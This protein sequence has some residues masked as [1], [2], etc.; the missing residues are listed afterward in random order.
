M[1]HR[2]LFRQ[3]R[4]TC[5]LTSDEALAPLM[6][7][8]AELA[9]RDDIAQPVTDF[10]RGLPDLINKVD[11]TYEQSDRDLDLR[12][13]SLEQSSAELNAI[14]EQMRGEI[15]SRNRVL[16]SVRSTIELMITDSGL[17][18]PAEED[19]EGLSAMLPELVKL[20]QARR[21]DLI[22]QRFAMDQ[23]AIVSIT[24]T[25][26]RI[27]YVNDKFCQISG[28]S[29]DELLGQGHKVIN[30]GQH[31]E[32]FFANM[33]QIIKSGKVWHGEICNI[34]KQGYNY[35]VEATIVPFLD[36]A[37]E[38]YEYIAIRTDI[39]AQKN[40]EHTLLQAKEAAESANRA[41]SDFLA[42]MSHEIRTPMN[43]IIG[44][45]DLVLDTKMDVS[46]RE[47]L[48]VV[49]SSA[50]ALLM[51]INDILDF[52][53]IEAGK[54]TLE[55]IPFDFTQV[56]L[57]T[58]RSIVV[59]AQ[60]KHIE[61]IL[62]MNQD[63]PRFVLGD[64]V[65]IRQVLLNLVGNAIK[66]TEHGE[67]VVRVRLLE[68][69]HEQ[70][71]IKIMV[72]DT[73][74]GI[75]KDSQKKIFE[76]FE[77]EDG[78]TTRRFGGTGLGLSITRRLV[79]MMGGNLAV[80]SEVGKGSTF[81]FDLAL[82]IDH[83]SKPTP[84][85][86][87][88]DALKGHCVLLVDDNVTQLNILQTMLNR[89]GAQTFI[90]LGAD[91]VLQYAMQGGQVPDCI[92]MNQG[93]AGKNGFHTALALSGIEAYQ[94]VPVVMLSA[95]GMPARA[96]QYL[97]PGIKRYLLKPICQEEVLKA[98]YGAIHHGDHVSGETMRFLAPL[99]D[100]PVKPMHI[101]LAEDNLLNQQLALALLKKWGHQ[102]IV[103]NNGAEALDLHLTQ[104]FDLILMDLQMPVMDGLAATDAIRHRE[105]QGTL[106][107]TI[108]AMTANA[109][110]GD[111]EKCLAA[112]MDDYL[113]KPFK[114][115]E[116]QRLL[117]KY[118]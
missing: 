18:M 14:N 27:K 61:L 109:L 42:N 1:I 33:W 117:K 103:A 110:D 53:K 52:S 89:R 108:I 80:E 76:A 2:T 41:K 21:L 8:L 114:Q 93:M 57:D 32:L 25:E 60:E 39:T 101:L 28:Y 68:A 69:A 77:Q 65:R 116:F 3:L 13:R 97:V 22:N 55:F 112:G 92:V 118:S 75:G 45:T 71:L 10:L 82:Q 34:N 23:H 113:S 64:P 87:R 19:L 30:S 37:G 43:G 6:Q 94:A 107:T 86:I 7:R 106:R 11:A 46:Q 44:M 73:G 72:T 26:G 98:V 100:E 102:I 115:E 49:K 66:F 104:H 38:P 105:Q 81:M 83:A 63:V 85:V 48:G 4:R 17:A 35:W 50:N 79:N 15:A 74:I 9:E 78:S 54:L 91:A 99:P 29:R 111:Q 40:A 59:R 47:Y 16:H 31:P 36:D 24:D 88:Q 96:Q 58:L 90:Q 70:M 95:T 84:S 56:V 20:Q 51:I 5:G 62:D 12:S 67:V